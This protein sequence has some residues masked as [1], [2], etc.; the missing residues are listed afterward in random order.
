M[1]V[2]RTVERAALLRPAAKAVGRAA[3]A[4]LC[5]LL[6]VGTGTVAAQGPVTDVYNRA[7]ARYLDANGNAG[8][9]SADVLVAID[10]RAAP[11][12]SSGT[13]VQ[14]CAGGNASFAHVVR[15]A[16]T[17]VDRLGIETITPAGFPAVAYHDL[18]EDGARQ[19]ADSV[20]T[21]GI[22]LA[23][24]EEAAVVIVVQV[25]PSVR[26]LETNIVVG[27]RSELDPAAWAETTNVIELCGLPVPT[28]DLVVDRA[29]A[30]PGDTLLYTITIGNAGDATSGA[31]VVTDTLP[32][33]LALIDTENVGGSTHTRMTS[34][35][36]A[37]AV[38]TFGYDSVA[39]G[40]TRVAHIRA[41]VAVA[42]TMLD[43]IRDVAWLAHRAD[44]VI[45]STAVT[46][47]RYPQIAVS[48]HV[49]NGSTFREGES[50]RFELG[51]SNTSDAALR[52]A[53]LTDSLPEGLSFVSASPAPDRVDGRVLQWSLGSLEPGEAGSI[54]LETLVD[55]LDQV[56]VSSLINRVTLNGG[57]GAAFAS[58]AASAA[59]AL[60]VRRFAG[61]ELVIR[62]RAGALEA[63]AGDAVLWTIELEN[64]GEVPLVDIV[65]T[66]LLPRTLSLVPGDIEGVDS[67]T[68]T[69]GGMRFHIA[70]P[71]APGE[72]RAIR[73]RTVVLGS[74]S[75]IANTAFATAESGVVLSDTAVARLR[76]HEGPAA[77]ARTLMGRVWLDVNDNRMQDEGEP[78]VAGVD[79]WTAQGVVVRTDEHGRF[80][81]Q[82]LEPGVHTLRVD[83]LGIGTEYRLPP[84]E[85]VA[86]VR[87]NGWTAGRAAIR[88]IPA[89]RPDPSL[90]DH[91]GPP[92]R[93]ASAPRGSGDAESVARESPSDSGSVAGVSIAPLRS[94]DERASD[95]RRELTQGPGVGFIA[96]ADGAVFAA[97]R[98]YVGARGEPGSTV[99][100]FDGDSLLAQG[101]IRPDGVHDFVALPLERGTHHLRLVMR[102]SWGTERADSIAVHRSGDAKIIEVIDELVV[103][104]AES[105][106]RRAVSARVLDEWG[107]PVTNRPYVAVAADNVTIESA[108]VDSGSVG[109]QIRADGDGW[110]RVAVR[111]GDRVGPAEVAFMLRE[112]SASARFDVI[113]PV[114][115]LIVTGSGRIGVGATEGAR[116]AVTARG[117]IDEQ[118]SLTLSYDTHRPDDESFLREHDALDESFYPTTGDASQRRVLSGSTQNF[119]ARVDRGRDWLAL[120]DV[121]TEGFADAADISSYDRSVDGVAARIG[122][123]EDVVWHA[124]GSATSETLAREQI[125]GNGTSGPF[126]L[127]GG[128]RPGTDRLALE[129][130]ARDNAARVIA[131]TTLDRDLDYQIDYAS[132]EVLLERP[133]PS[134]DPNGNPLYLVADVERRSDA[135]SWLGGVRAD[136]DVA[137]LAGIEQVDSLGVAVSAIRDG[138]DAP[139]NAAI[140]L[141]AANVG[142]RAGALGGTLELVHGATADSSA[143][144]TRI[145]AA[146][147]VR[148]RARIEGEWLSVG[149][150][151]AAGANPRLRAGVDEL[152]LGARMEARAG[153]MVGIEHERQ[154]FGQLDIDRSATYLRVDQDLGERDL[155]VQTGMVGNGGPGGAGSAL[156]TRA[157]LRTSEQDEVWIEANRSLGGDSSSLAPSQ[158]GMG[159]SYRV[160][161]GLRVVGAHRQ[162]WIAGDQYAQSDV[163]LRAEPIQD[164]A[165]WG[166]V[167]RTGGE[168]TT[169]AAHAAAFGWSQRLRFD[170][171][172]TL[173]GLYE[174]RLNIDDAPLTDPVRALPFAQRE[175][176]FWSAAVGAEWRNR[177]RRLSGHGELHDGDIAS[178][179]RFELSGDVQV[180]DGL[181][182]LTRQDWLL[183]RRND[184]LGLVTD[185][186]DRSLMALAFRPVASDDWN[187]LA[188]IE[189]RR[190]DAPVAPNV[191]RGSSFRRLIGTL[192][193]VWAPSSALE[194]A[195]RYSIR[196]NA[197]AQEGFGPEAMQATA[198]HLGATL[199]QRLAGAVHSLALDPFRVRLDSRVL[200]SPTAETARWS[201][202]PS[203][204]YE[205]GGTLELEAGWRLG[206]LEDVDFQR[207]GA[208]GVFASVQ[209]SFTEEDASG[210][211]A[212]W[213][214]RLER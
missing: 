168:E 17:S 10:L 62:K 209:L 186:R 69:N 133:L 176:D 188:R 28:L 199:D 12:I 161:P 89:P 15:N 26:V 112:D 91:V 65:V 182:L 87:M 63:S 184:P 35:S 75:A 178:G 76:V 88:L 192:D 29:E 191:L 72:T 113:A 61:E 202:A 5:L 46:T 49:L 38:L 137:S 41:L 207:T 131:Y 93:S 64:I 117:A 56:G 51:W 167:Q 20:L 11:E 105:Q 128:I 196:G 142:V 82:D 66:D 90:E 157:T 144:A 97:S 34:S 170:S 193:L 22:L 99:H 141:T 30:V 197:F 179:Y 177:D 108:D 146:W 59:A 129:V 175:D 152:R 86:D 94:A 139:G 206:D 203:L 21:D 173:S 57:A 165:V 8:A 55:D 3:A 134:T 109:H 98:V 194:A 13:R 130:R 160:L 47:I 4:V 31:I 53:V 50:V 153:T 118:T 85:R 162:V 204:L 81:L 18:N 54:T 201:L 68:S 198:H 92:I 6:G 185:R 74:G 121:R 114:R 123:G 110:A 44:T 148:E 19:P 2:P 156:S 9:A 77:P 73:Y 171:G 33:G 159:A 140:D 124:F 138:S 205:L 149:T 135:R 169:V 158:V 16:G 132:G 163:T 174:R 116:A 136:V 150:G 200:Y 115:P 1:G 213:K 119:S 24:G 45:A 36:L 122:T 187:A 39:P 172:W 154:S 58:A 80:S 151:F 208:S 212:F 14:A 102:N 126:R 7:D 143:L 189:W 60:D 155:S 147:D 23:P 107:V 181:A 70:G 166:G 25:D 180:T 27:A 42:D 195:F 111:A 83:T 43:E 190:S 125:R 104:R 214:A 211:A 79:V 71:L 32:D 103:L 84:N 48:K 101:V 210:L 145:G 120:G 96:P 52:N 95:R 164:G 100:L 78:G 183:E 67:V 106:E 37:R 127:G 40:E